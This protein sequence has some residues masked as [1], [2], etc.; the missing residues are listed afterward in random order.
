[1]QTSTW[2][3]PV[4]QN[5]L[6]CPHETL[7]SMQFGPT[8]QTGYYG[9]QQKSFD[10]HSLRLSN[11]HAFTQDVSSSANLQS[12]QSPQMWSSGSQS[13]FP[14]ISPASGRHPA[15]NIVHHA[16]LQSKQVGTL[17]VNFNHD[18]Q[19][20][21]TTIQRKYMDPH[22]VQN[23]NCTVIAP[24]FSVLSVPSNANGVFD[25]SYCRNGSIPPW[26]HP[27]YR[28]HH[29]VETAAQSQQAALTAWISHAAQ[30]F[31]MNQGQMSV[32]GQHSETPSS[33][34]HFPAASHIPVDSLLPSQ[35]RTSS[36]HMSQNQVQNALCQPPSRGKNVGYIELNHSSRPNPPL[37]Y[38]ARLNSANQNKSNRRLNQVPP[39]L[40][41]DK[42]QSQTTP[43]SG[44]HRQTNFAT[45]SA[46]QHSTQPQVLQSNNT[47]SRLT[48]NSQDITSF[49]TSTSQTLSPT[50]GSRSTNYSHSFLFHLL[51]QED[52]KK[53]TGLTSFS[54]CFGSQFAKSKCGSQQF[55]H[56]NTAGYIITAENYTQGRAREGKEYQE[57]CKETGISRGNGIGS[58]SHLAEPQKLSQN[59]MAN[60]KK[61]NE[62]VQSSIDLV[63]S[64]KLVISPPRLVRQLNKA[65]AVVPPISHQASSHVQ[66]NVTTGTH[67][68]LPLNTNTVKN[69]FKECENMEKETIVPNVTF[70]LTEDLPHVP[71]SPSSSP[72][73]GSATDTS[74]NVSET[75]TSENDPT[76]GS[77]S[78]DTS[79]CKNGSV[80]TTQISNKCQD[81]VQVVDST[82]ES[83]VEQNDVEDP[84]DMSTV[85]VVNYTLKEL[86]DLVKSLDVIPALSANSPTDVLKCILDLYYDGK[87]QNLDK[88]AS[89]EGLFKTSSECCIKEMHAVVLQYLLPKHLKMLG[90]CSQILINETTLPSEDFRSSWLNVDGHPADVEKV[91]A[92]PI[93]E[94][95]L[96]WCKK[97]SQSVSESVVNMVDS[98]VQINTD[99]SE[100]LG[101]HAHKNIP[102]TTT[103]NIPEY[104]GHSDPEHSAAIFATNGCKTDMMILEKGLISRTPNK[105]SRMQLHDEVDMVKENKRVFTESSLTSS[106]DKCVTNNSDAFEETDASDDSDSTNDL[107]E[108]ILLS[109]EDARKI[110]SE[111]SECNQK[112]ESNGTCQEERKDLVRLCVKNHSD[113]SKVKPLNDFKFTCPHVT[114]LVSGSDFFC[115]S[116]WNETPLLDIDQD[117]TLLTLKEGELNTDYQRQRHSPQSGKTIEYPSAP[118]YIESSSKIKS[119]IS[120]KRSDGFDVRRDPNSQ[121]KSSSPPPA[122]EAKP[123]IA[124]TKNSSITN[125]VAELGQ[126][127]KKPEHMD[128]EDEDSPS[129]TK[130]PTGMVSPSRNLSQ[131]NVKSP[132]TD[133]VPDADDILFSP[134]IVI[135]NSNT[136]KKHPSEHGSTSRDDGQC[137]DESKE[138]GNFPITKKLSPKTKLGTPSQLPNFSGTSKCKKAV[139]HKQKRPII[140]GKGHDGQSKETKKVRLELYGSNRSNSTC[141]DEGQS[142]SIP[143]Y[144]SISPSLNIGKGYT[145]EPSAKQK[146]YSQWSTTFI[147]PQKNSTSYKKSQKHMEDLLKSKTQVLKMALEERI[148]GTFCK[149]SIQ[150]S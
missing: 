66:Q 45:F 137:R 127:D 121:T 86:E 6:P 144:L 62:E 139:P 68:S 34:A 100:D 78:C 57:P 38:R 148:M 112:R 135:K 40:T 35:I 46:I 32:V 10:Q 24:P 126:L 99:N 63:D 49:S 125:L 132:K 12:N 81:T 115:Q 95:N 60:W 119:V 27:L 93:S 108:I 14:Y 72:R 70:K 101:V 16:S 105:L 2:T 50:T 82:S 116:C 150:W 21:N 58:G 88:I 130:I 9:L 90:N 91:L 47:V 140:K 23:T 118:V 18:P 44:H 3:P 52:N 1:M 11:P 122:Q 142:P 28:Q 92:E 69:L 25:N 104:I 39:S 19:V 128:N 138:S 106:S 7:S 31:N 136:H 55:T 102:K 17:A 43:I 29:G 145:D 89:L 61:R 84:F 53:L 74:V 42:V 80:A 65:V 30:T 41:Q 149:Q 109:S 48:T 143:V 141:H 114:G 77:Q 20:I 79:Q 13:Q 147:H 117:E 113:S 87:K 22:S 94:Y 124:G 4:R 64:I 134:D 51:Q 33:V 67:D 96:T 120:S 71:C 123:G 56:D 37:P 129:G 85:P 131:K 110:F 111:F 76:S 36:G 146:V 97:V 8:L 133:A 75:P 5:S 103:D 83:S 54:N 98:L 59:E 26:Q 107:P 73:L 15:P